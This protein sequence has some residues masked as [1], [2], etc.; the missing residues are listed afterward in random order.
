VVLYAGFAAAYFLLVLHF[1]GG[2][3]REVFDYNKIL[4]A[5]VALTLVCAQGFMLEM[6]TSGLL[7]FIDRMQAI[8]PALHRLSR[9]HETITRPKNVPG[10]LVYR[11]AGPLLFFNTTYFARRV[12]ELID[13]ADPPVIF[14]LINAEAIVDMDMTAVEVLEVL[15]KTLESKN[16]AL[17]MCQ[18][19][20]HFRE[21]LM[22]TL[23]PRRPGFIVYPSVAATVRE[24]TKVQPVKARKAGDG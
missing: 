20:G 4:Y 19:K 3:M 5:I 15:Y 17:G 23:L 18:V 2:W 7:W 6:L 1:Q 11:F 9:P 13:T 10:L 8:I 12:H 21:V 14:F 24:L 16:I 22:S